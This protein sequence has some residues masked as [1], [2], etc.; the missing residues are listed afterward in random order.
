MEVTDPHTQLTNN[1]INKYR[2]AGKIVSKVLD[3]LVKMIKPGALVM[4]ICRE[5]DKLLIEELKKV[6]LKV[7]NK[8]ISFPTCVNINNIGAYFCTTKDEDVVINQGDLIKIELGA[9]I[10]NFPALQ[11]YTILVNEGEEESINSKKGRLLRAC[12][13][14]SKEIL[15]LMKPGN[16]NKDV[17]RV[18]ESICKKYQCSLPVVQ[19]MHLAPTTSHQMSR[20]VIDSYND[21]DDE[22]IHQMILCKDNEEVYGFRM[23]EDEFMEDDVFAIDITLCS[24]DGKLGR[25]DDFVNVYR[26]DHRR[27]CNLKLKASRSVISSFKNKAFPINID[28]ELSNRFKLGLKEPVNKGLIVPYIPVKEK[29]NEFIGRIKFTVIV[30][31]KPILI[32]G[33]SLDEQLKKL[34]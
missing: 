8:G 34:S 28:S 32:T 27:K 1:N 3:K 4:D 18:L 25:M 9:H 7:L 21:D 31:K 10:D 20:Y 22:Y 30:K 12:S 29:N 15:S 17:V 24:G 11:V 2:T 19:D 33:R 16:T 14:S 13:E 5:G 23:L 6:Y 26:R